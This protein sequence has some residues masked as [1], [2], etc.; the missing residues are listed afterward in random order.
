MAD[1]AETTET[2]Q[3]GTESTE[4]QATVVTFTQE[5]VNDLIA[6]ERGKIE[7]KFS[8]YDDL[9]NQLETTKQTLESTNATLETI[10]GERDAARSEKESTTLDNLK[11]RVAMQKSLPLNLVDRLKGQNEEELTA[12]ADSLLTVIK[13][14]TGSFDAGVR[15]SAQ[16]LDIENEDDPN[17]ILDWA[18]N[19]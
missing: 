2:T 6:K 1:K 7:K 11:L 9:K 8:D 4:T 15:T 19:H 18:K 17:K 10:T 12:D 16:P 3:G 5:Q 14:P 13:P